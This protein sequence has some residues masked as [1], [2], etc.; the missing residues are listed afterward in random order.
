MSE[1]NVK[2]TVKEIYSKI[3]TDNSCCC[4]NK[5]FSESYENVQGYEPTAD[6]GLGC[7]IPTEFANIK[8]GDT[9]LDLGSGAGNDCFVARRIVGDSGRVIGVDFTNEMI[10]RARQNCGNLGYNNVSFVLAEI[11]NLPFADNTV[12]VV[13]SNCVMNL[14]PNKE[15][16]YSEI[17]RV[18][19]SGGHFSISDIIIYGELSEKIRNAA[20]MTAACISGAVSKEEYLR[21]VEKAGFKNI[22]IQSE[23]KVTV[24]TGELLLYVN[25][26]DLEEFHKS[27]AGVGSINI[28]AEKE[29]KCC[30]G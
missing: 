25:Q 21:I 19:K 7:G 26:E 9:V 11:E 18:L 17:F 13:V 6:L 5:Y 23:K 1:E 15:K 27:G 20:T 2:N 10:G 4:G 16:A 22:K 29:M 8:E 12:D 28:Y 30:C 24:E 3:A 14:V